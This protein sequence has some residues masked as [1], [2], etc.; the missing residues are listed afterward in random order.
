MTRDAE[1]NPSRKL[2]K[3]YV[4][5]LLI[6]ESYLKKKKEIYTTW[7]YR[8]QGLFQ[9]FSHSPTQVRYNVALSAKDSQA[10][11]HWNVG[12]RLTLLAVGRERSK[13]YAEL[14]LLV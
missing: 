7:F 14:F 13:G 3:D 9:T 1:D 11:V 2:L 4:R 8:L 10:T 12:S 6:P 5:K